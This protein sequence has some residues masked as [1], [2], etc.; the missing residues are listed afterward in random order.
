MLFR[1]GE[2]IVSINEEIYYILYSPEELKT[3]KRDSLYY[4]YRDLKGNLFISEESE[5][6][7]L[8]FRYLEQ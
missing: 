8:G 5:L 2:S 1:S 4:L 3:K 6:I 7:E